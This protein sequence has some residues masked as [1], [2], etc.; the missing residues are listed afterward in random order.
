MEA[1]LHLDIDAMIKQHEIQADDHQEKNLESTH[2]KISSESNQEK[3]LNNKVIILMEKDEELLGELIIKIEEKNNNGAQI[4]QDNK[5]GWSSKMTTWRKECFVE[6]YCTPRVLRIGPRYGDPYFIE[7]KE[8]KVKLAA[9]FIESF[10]NDKTGE[11]LLKEIRKN[12]QALK[13]CFHEDVITKSDDD[14]L[15]RLFF[16]EGCAVL[17]F[18]HSY[19]QNE[20]DEFGIDNHQASLIREDLFLLQNQIPFRVFELVVNLID[21]SDQLKNDIVDFLHINN[22]MA[23]MNYF[24]GSKQWTELLRINRPNGHL[25]DLLHSLILF[26]DYNDNVGG[27]NS[28][29]ENNV[30]YLPCYDQQKNSCCF[31]CFACFCRKRP[32]LEGF[33]QT[34]QRYYDNKRFFRNVQELKSAGIEFKPCS[35]LATVSFSSRCYNIRG[36]LKLPPI[37]VDEWTECRLMNLVAYE[38]CLG[39]SK[40][41]WY[42]VTSYIKFMD[43][44]IDTEQDVKELRASCILWNRL[45]SDAKVAKLFNDI[46]SKCFEPPQDVYSDVRTEIQTHCDRKC[47]I[48][49]A[50]VY[51]EHFSSP[52]TVLALLAAGIVLSL[53]TIQTWYA[54]HPN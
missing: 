24:R 29:K 27:N 45:S 44:L 33:K 19:L 30:K 48:W 38:M 9:K 14:F 7:E 16:L 43:F 15:A 37:T 42:F 47:A 50:Q 32:S 41:N 4:E 10:S 1:E 51:H 12:I 2:H 26:G 21:D 34:R 17:Q 18:I 39:G 23:S 22:I 52:W 11:S 49:M 35:G 20:L 5:I 13:K 3:G 54:V 40:K 31:P 36:H 25:L 46:G 8:L 6:E 53:T 28:D